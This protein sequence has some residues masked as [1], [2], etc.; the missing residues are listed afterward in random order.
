MGLRERIARIL[1]QLPPKEVCE[2][3]E[4][5]HAVLPR[6]KKWDRDL[7][8][9]FASQIP[10]PVRNP[11]VAAQ[12]IAANLC[13][14]GKGRV[15]SPWQRTEPGGEF[16][17]VKISSVE[18]NVRETDRK[19]GY[20]MRYEILTGSPAGRSFR[21]WLSAQRFMAFVRPVIGFDHP[22]GRSS[23]TIRPLVYRHPTDVVG[24]FVVIG[25]APGEELR[26]ESFHRM[27]DL[28]VFNRKILAL[29]FRVI[30][31]CPDGHPDTY[32]CH[33]CPKGY[34][35][36]VAAV[37]PHTI[38]LPVVETDGGQSRSISERSVSPVR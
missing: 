4:L 33:R 27:A 12:W 13:F 30:E 22:S 29:R 37:R 18:P 6:S 14:A 5:I 28:R 35:E 31:K 25:L 9:N 19:H 32:P 8:F 23:R 17:T 2:V 36:C 11:Q 7:V 10:L 21:E 1:H 26:S 15:V 34:G 16:V 38:T 3:V 24:C 20:K